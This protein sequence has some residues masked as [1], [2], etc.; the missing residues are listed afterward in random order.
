MWKPRLGVEP[1]L[2]VPTSGEV[3]L[4]V[5]V[6]PGVLGKRAPLPISEGVMDHFS[7]LSSPFTDVLAVGGGFLGSSVSEVGV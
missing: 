5:A 1:R 7:S 4:G 2:E 3:A 6:F